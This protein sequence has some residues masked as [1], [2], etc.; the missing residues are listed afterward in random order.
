MLQQ[1]AALRKLTKQELIEFFNDFIKVGA[2]Q[3]KTLSIGV[4]GNLHSSEYTAEKSEPLQPYCLKIDDIFSFRRSQ[5]LYG[6]F[7]GVFDHAKL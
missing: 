7:R 1:V 6:S 4:Y 2:P 3:R 5:S